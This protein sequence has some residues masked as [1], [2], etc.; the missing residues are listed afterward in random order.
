MTHAPPPRPPPAPGPV[1]PATDDHRVAL[2]GAVR[3]GPPLG[4]RQRRIAGEKNQNIKQNF[5]DQLLEV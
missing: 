3:A 4:L 2:E 1:L 5:D